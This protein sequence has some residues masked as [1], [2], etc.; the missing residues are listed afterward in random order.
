MDETRSDE[1]VETLLS[2]E[3]FRLTEGTETGEGG[4]NPPLRVECGSRLGSIFC[5]CGSGRLYASDF[6]VMMGTGRL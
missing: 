1:E 4:R 3:F 6:T 2:K 5:W